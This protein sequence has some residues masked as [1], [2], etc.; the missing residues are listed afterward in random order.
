[1]IV[2]RKATQNEEDKIR[3]ILDKDHFKKIDLSTYMENT[4]VVELEG[5]IVGCGGLAIY[6]D[7]AFIKFVAILSEYQ[8]QSLGDGL[9]RALINYVDR[10][11]VKKIYLVNEKPFD[12]FKRFG[13]NYIN[14]KDFY[15]Q[16]Y[17]LK[18]LNSTINN[19]VYI[20]EL[21]IN[22]FFNN[23]HCHS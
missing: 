13:F 1:M 20:M 6:D 2:I 21:D 3:E 19:F 5:F 12:Y 17:N 18:E 4:M 11:N 16:G 22:E 14:L 15:N 7:I 8:N 10:R 23:E 9:V